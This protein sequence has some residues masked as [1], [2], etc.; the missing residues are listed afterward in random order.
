MSDEELIAL[1]QKGFFP[2]PEE[3]E[4]AFCQRIEEVKKN[5]LELKE[6]AIPYP[7][8]D[9][10]RMRLKEIFDFVPD[11]LPAFYSNRRLM[12]WQ[13]AACWV[14]GKRVASIQLRESL[15]KGNLLGLIQREEILTHEAVHAARSPFEEDRFEEYFAFA[16]SEKKWRRTLGPIV[17]RPWEV[18]PFLFC[19][20]VGPFFPAAFFCAGLWAGLGFVRLVRGHRILQRA[21]DNLSQITRDARFIRAILV[22]LTDREIE[23]IAK[24]ESVS[25]TTLRWRLIRLAYWREVNHGT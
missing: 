15:R 19:C 24:G 3:S 20:L 7:H 10:T 6:Q 23:K 18:W 13:A 1:N 25:D 12:P 11:C 14:E 4:E 17:K 16:T 21:A 22:R 2:G 9:W 5:I 8:W